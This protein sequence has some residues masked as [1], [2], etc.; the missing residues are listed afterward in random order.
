LADGW[1]RR[2]AAA[3]AETPLEHRIT[4]PRSASHYANVITRVSTVAACEDMVKFVRQRDIA[5]AGVS[6][7]YSSDEPQAASRNDERL[8]CVRGI[9]PLAFGL[10][11]AEGTSNSEATLYRFVVE[12]AEP[13]V[14][15]ALTQVLQTS[16]TFV[17]HDLRL[18]MFAIWSLGSPEPKLFWDTSIAAKAFDLGKHHTRYRADQNGQTTHERSW[19]DSER[20]S[21]TVPLEALAS[22]YGIDPPSGGWQGSRL[23]RATPASPVPQRMAE[24]LANSAT[25]VTRLYPFQVLEATTRGSLNHLVRIEM[26]WVATT[27]RMTW[28]GVRLDRSRSSD[29]LPSCREHLTR[30]SESLAAQGVRDPS[31]DEVLRQFFERINL[32]DRFRDGQGR[33]SFDKDRLEAAKGL[34]PAVPLIWA[35]RRVRD[36]LNLNIFDPTFSGPDGRVHP[37]Y[38]VLGARTGRLT[39]RHPNLPGI[40]RIFR[41]LVVPDEGCGIGEVDFCQFEP[42]IAGAVYADERLVEMFNTDDLYSAM[43]KEFFQHELTS[44][45]KSLTAA[46]FKTRHRDKRDRM[47]ICT[48]GI[49]YG[50]TNE[51]LAKQMNVAVQLAAE[52]RGRFLAMFP[53]L[54]C[55]L[56]EV[57]VLGAVRGGGVTTSGLRRYRPGPGH[58][59]NWER[60]WFA[61]FPIQGTAA[62]LFKRAGNRLDRLYPRYKARL[63]VPMHDAFVFEAPLVALQEVADLTSRV[64]QEV[65]EEEFPELRPRVEV[66][67]CHPGCWN[68]DGHSDSIDRWREDPTYGI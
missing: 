32:L 38:V 23:E 2:I 42:G 4:I 36:F 19:F 43:A 1:S 3:T 41:P 10:A 58:P 20:R 63:I 30:L 35:Y 12:A 51:G 52:F 66:N 64:M 6:L 33:Y 26:P 65:V 44:D 37:E 68:K 62:D 40:G 60:N 49:I 67:I 24:D 47:K 15:A 56:E 46:D 29:L 25:C 11:F 59:S 34:H 28:N 53:Q 48:L 16:I 8:A 7:L 13:E 54:Q 50:L 55:G 31:Q 39:A 57:R 21:K 18:F 17:G 9:R 22:R 45:S 61:N 5:F 27:A 14:F